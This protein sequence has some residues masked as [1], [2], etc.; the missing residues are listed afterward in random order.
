MMCKM[1]LLMPIFLKRR[2]KS[3]RVFVLHVGMYATHRL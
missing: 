2:W 3:E 1:Y